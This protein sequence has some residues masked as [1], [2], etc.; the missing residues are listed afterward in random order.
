[1][2]LLH[3]LRIDIDGRGI[4]AKKFETDGNVHFPLSCYE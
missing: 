1:M 3:G 4:G 2:G